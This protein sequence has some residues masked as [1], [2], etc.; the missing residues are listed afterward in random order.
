MVRAAAPGRRRGASAVV[1]GLQ[2]A[3]PWLWLGHGPLQRG[4]LLLLVVVGRHGRLRLRKGEGA[5][6][7]LLQLLVRVWVV[8]VG[9]CRGVV[10]WWCGGEFHGCRRQGRTL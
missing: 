9:E 3:H 8:C 1:P 2:V 6:A 10:V 7:L 4:G 5:V